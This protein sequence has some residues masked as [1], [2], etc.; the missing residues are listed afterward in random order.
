VTYMSPS[1]AAEV[2]GTRI[3]HTRPTTWALAAI[4]LLVI[5]FAVAL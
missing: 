1:L 4:L 5:V 2:R 3:P